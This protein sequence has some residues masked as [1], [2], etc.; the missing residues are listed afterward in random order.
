MV[1]YPLA[2]KARPSAVKL[3]TP[4]DFGPYL[5]RECRGLV[6]WHPPPHPSQSKLGVEWIGQ[7]GSKCSKLCWYADLSAVWRL[8]SQWVCSLYSCHFIRFSTAP[9]PLSLRILKKS[10]ARQ[11]LNWTLYFF[12]LQ[13]QSMECCP[14]PPLCVSSPHWGFKWNCRGSS[15]DRSIL[16]NFYIKISQQ[17]SY[18]PGL[19]TG[20]SF[21]WAAEMLGW[22]SEL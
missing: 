18:W 15:Q 7:N 11:Q 5:K 6:K 12:D 1:I 9:R 19:T 14:Q 8:L 21:H 17:R 4:E 10:K 16:I 13:I 3:P 22:C 20:T 2:C